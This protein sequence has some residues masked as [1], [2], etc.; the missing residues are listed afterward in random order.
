M[1]PF[2]DSKIIPDRITTSNIPNTELLDESLNQIS[3]ILDSRKV[4]RRYDYFIHW[5]DTP[6]TENSWVPFAEIPN[7]L[8]HILE[9]FHR[10]NPS[11]PHPPRFHFTTPIDNSPSSFNNIPL[12]Q[13]DN[14]SLSTRSPSPP[15][16]SRLRHYQPP[17]QQKTRSGRLVHPPSS[18]EY[19]T[20]S[21]K[22]GVM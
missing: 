15:P 22:K 10:R 13:V 9:Q 8:F 18:K 7:N 11:R 16:E 17:V 1:E 5:K 6:D 14:H 20:S 21:L 12:L 2:V 19:T 4:G 3:L